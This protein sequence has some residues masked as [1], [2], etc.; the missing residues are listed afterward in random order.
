MSSGKDRSEL[1]PCA[2]PEQAQFKGF[3]ECMFFYK[4]LVIQND[5][6]L[7]HVLSRFYSR[8]WSGT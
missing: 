8:A 4:T 6:E 1:H 3:S 7:K 5:V 2:E